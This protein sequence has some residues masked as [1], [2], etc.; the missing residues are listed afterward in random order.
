MLK[1]PA[2]AA[3]AARD[4][5]VVEIDPGTYAGGVA[6]WPQ[7]RLTVRGIGGKPVVTAD[8]R[9]IDRRDIWLFTGDEITVENVA[10]SGARSLWGKRAGIR[11]IGMWTGFEI[12][13]AGGQRDG[14]AY[15][16]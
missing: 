12:R 13:V 2:Q 14:P 4:G 9:S 15:G 5:D 8:G 6:R 7:N 16:Q 1:T 11:H 10:L 3:V